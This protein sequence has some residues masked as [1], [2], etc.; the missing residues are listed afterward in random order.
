M[1]PSSRKLTSR[2]PQSGDTSDQAEHVPHAG[3]CAG[4]VI[5]AHAGGVAAA[6]EPR[7]A[8]AGTH[9]RLARSA[10]ARPFVGVHASRQ[11]QTHQRKRSMREEA[12]RS[13]LRGAHISDQHRHPRARL[14]FRA[15]LCYV[16]LCCAVDHLASTLWVRGG[17]SACQSEGIR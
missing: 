1:C 7:E 17:E 4:G 12:G 13:R 5:R 3:V 15:V 16:V 6:P 9:D 10:A 11:W 2:N 8:E 14:V